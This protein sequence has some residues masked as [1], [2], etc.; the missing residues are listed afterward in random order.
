MFEELWKPISGYEGIYE[1]SSLGRVRSLDRVV[2]DYRGI[3]KS[4]GGKI[5]K[6]GVT[7]KGYYIVSLNSVDK[8]HT[9]TVHR[10]VANAFVPNL[11]NKPQVNHINGIKTD[12]RI[13]NLEWLTNEENM[14]HAINNGLAN[15]G[16]RK[17]GSQ[18]KKITICSKKSNNVVPMSIEERRELDKIRKR[19]SRQSIP[20][21]Q[22]LKEQEE[23]RQKKVDELKNIILDNPSLNKKQLAEKMGVSRKTVYRLYKFL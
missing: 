4:V 15:K 19:E 13:C 17:K 6:P 3:E 10:L 7:N 11:D 18:N 1:V 22:Y 8:R 16:G 14:K 20:R 5:L 12:N 21:E 2:V 23:I 9:L